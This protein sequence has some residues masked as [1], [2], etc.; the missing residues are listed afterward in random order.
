MATNKR[1]A[2]QQAAKKDTKMPKS[3][4]ASSKATLTTRAKS[5]SPAKSKS[6]SPSPAQT[7]GRA[8][9]GDSTSRSASK[10][11]RSKSPAAPRSAS[12]SKGKRAPSPSPSKKKAAS[13]EKLSPGW[14]KVVSKKE[15]KATKKETST[16][17]EL[18][19]VPVESSSS[20]SSSKI[21]KKVSNGEET[22]AKFIN[23]RNETAIDDEQY[24]QYVFRTG[25][26]DQWGR[27]VAMAATTTAPLFVSI[28]LLCYLKGD[29]PSSQLGVLFL[30][31]YMAIVIVTILFGLPAVLMQRVVTST[32]T[33]KTASKSSEL[34]VLCLLLVI[35]TAVSMLVTMKTIHW[36]QFI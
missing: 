31:I 8:K 14:M 35:I 27:T 23:S 2:K 15:K 22:H 26:I 7:R 9:T 10:A 13:A 20:R 3:V 11:P 4:A 19:P 6:R 16:A 36:I 21:R 29:V 17:S 30:V 5:P 24:I 28:P 18:A 34:E 33:G 1:K 12:S 32:L 25:I